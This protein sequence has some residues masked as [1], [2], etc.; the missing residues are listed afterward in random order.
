MNRKTEK[1]RK[2]TENT[3]KK[4]KITEKNKKKR[5][6]SD[7]GAQLSLRGGGRGGYFWL[8]TLFCTLQVITPYNNPRYCIFFVYYSQQVFVL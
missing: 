1:H 2:T 4:Q 8:L 7:H 5:G 6:E 3:G